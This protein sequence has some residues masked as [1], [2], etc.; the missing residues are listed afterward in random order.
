MKKITLNLMILN[1]NNNIDHSNHSIDI[2]EW[3][4]KLMYCEK[5]NIT[6]NKWK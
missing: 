2:Y 6:M 1:N 5:K 4:M 3:I